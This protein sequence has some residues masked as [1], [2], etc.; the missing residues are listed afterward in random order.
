M[1]LGREEWLRGAA[2]GSAWAISWRQQGEPAAYN[3]SKGSSSAHLVCI[4]LWRALS[5]ASCPRPLHSEADVA[6]R[7]LGCG[8]KWGRHLCD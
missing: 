7:I 2:A 5:A 3:L 1:N 6:C 4:G 8:R